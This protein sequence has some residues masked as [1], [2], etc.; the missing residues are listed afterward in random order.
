MQARDEYE[1]TIQETEAAYIKVS[2]R[3]QLHHTH[4]SQ[5][6]FPLWQHIE[7]TST[8]IIYTTMPCWRCEMTVTLQLW[9]NK[10]GSPFIFL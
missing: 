9:S 1:K 10:L 8:S 4:T 7:F 3:A 6:N 2:M 5:G